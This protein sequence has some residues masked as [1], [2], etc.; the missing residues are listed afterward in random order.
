MVVVTESDGF[1]AK[2]TES[3]N[4]ELL[5][6]V[7]VYR[8]GMDPAALEAIERELRSRGVTDEQVTEHGQRLEGE[9]LWR[10]PGLAW[11]CSYCTRPAVAWEPD[12]VRLFWFI[13]I[14]PRRVR[15]CREHL[16]SRYR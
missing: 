14:F 11:S 9:V 15:C 6:R 10:E 4:E 1:A 5:D 13:P 3:T 7:T 8:A 2:L 12:W 16:E